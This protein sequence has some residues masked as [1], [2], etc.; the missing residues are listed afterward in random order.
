[1]EGGGA[2]TI[3]E[4]APRSLEEQGSGSREDRGEGSGR[5]CPLHP[6]PVSRGPQHNWGN[7]CVWGVKSEREE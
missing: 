2:R 4:K 3:Q 6:C 1:M 7:R 5:L